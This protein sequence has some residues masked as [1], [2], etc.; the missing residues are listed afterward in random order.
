MS[1]TSRTRAERRSVLR[2][3]ADMSAAAVL[4]I[5][6]FLIVPGVLDP[7]P[8]S[9]E[10]I[11]LACTALIPVVMFVV[12]VARF[13]A[14]ADEFQRLTALRA[15]AVGFGVAMF[16]AMAVAI[17]EGAGLAIPSGVWIVFLAGMSAW[18]VCMFVFTS[19]GQR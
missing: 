5:A 6:L 9:A 3:V 2:Y 12:A 11:L 13:L 16:A 15:F 14:R 18:G 19:R 10:A 4:F 8:G 1:D 7:A 17:L